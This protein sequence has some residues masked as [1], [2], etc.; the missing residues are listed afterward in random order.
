MTFSSFFVHT[1]NYRKD[2]NFCVLKG[3]GFV[4]L[5]QAKKEK[6]TDREKG[7]GSWVMSNQTS[8]TTTGTGAPTTTPTQSSLVL[9]AVILAPIVGVLLFAAVICKLYMPLSQQTNIFFFFFFFFIFL[10]FSFCSGLLLSEKQGSCD[11]K[12]EFVRQE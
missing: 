4:F 2:W 6:E 5:F 10:F 3:R 12:S 9:W 8:T 11:W 1:G 7:K